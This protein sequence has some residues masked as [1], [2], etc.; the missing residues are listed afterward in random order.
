MSDTA[1]KD[2]KPGDLGKLSWEPDKV[3]GSLDVVFQHATKKA[4]DAIGWYLVSKRRK[5]IWAVGLRV[6]AI[7][8]ASAA[9]ILPMLSQIF[10]TNG[11]PV[12][13]PVWASVLLGLAAAMVVL[14]RFFGFSS[15]WMRFIAAE[16]ELHQ[17]LEEFQMEWESERAAWK[18]SGPNDDQ[19]QKMLDRAK[20]FVLQVNTLVR[21]ET[22]AWIAEFRSAL[23]QV[24][25]LAKARAAARSASAKG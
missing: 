25:E 11:N 9:G 24:D 1:K 23:K 20:D 12:I 15:G 3:E 17:I 14:D 21:D 6:G 19:V 16:M 13:P 22:N 5:Q 4:K 2:L 10:V 18:G 8:S 7:L